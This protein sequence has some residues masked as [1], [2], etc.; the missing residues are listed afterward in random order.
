MPPSPED[1]I[2]RFQSRGG[3][4]VLSPA[5][6][7][8]R[9][10]A[11]SGIVL[12][13]DGVFNAGMKDTERGSPFGEADSM[14]LNLLR[15]ALRQDLSGIPPTAIITGESNATALRFAEREHLHAGYRGIGH[16][17]TAIRDFAGRFDVDLQS[18]AVIFDD[19]NDLSMAA[20]GGLRILVRR[21]ASLLL[22]EYAVRHGLCD[23]VTFCEGGENAVRESCELILGLMGKL[24]FAL[25]ERTQRSPAYN[26]YFAERQAIKPAFL[27]ESQGSII[28]A[29]AA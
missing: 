29:G 10:Q 1:V 15:F 24:D 26:S 5:D 23:Y 2:D 13:W 22:E 14:G 17:E 8:A 6:M 16:K 9:A 20:A 25:S 7:V 3:R 11:V 19:V 27:A 12:D 18:V 4:F 21:K 28:P